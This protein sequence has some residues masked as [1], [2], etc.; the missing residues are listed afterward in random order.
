MIPPGD[1][2]VFKNRSHVWRNHLAQVRV[3]AQKHIVLAPPPG[4]P[5]IIHMYQFLYQFLYYANQFFIFF[6]P[7]LK[8]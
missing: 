6:S 5:G 3:P 8:T 1:T 2:G 4:P 7:I